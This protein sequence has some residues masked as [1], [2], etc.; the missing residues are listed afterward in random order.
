MEQ[1][2]T[3][4]GN[5]SIGKHQKSI[6]NKEQRYEEPLRK[7]RSPNSRKYLNVTI[8][9]LN[10]KTH[11]DQEC[12]SIRNSSRK[13]FLLSTFNVRTLRSEDR[14]LELEYGL[15]QTNYG[16]MGMSE[17]R[18][19]GEG[20]MVKQNGDLFSYIGANTSHKGVGFIINAALKDYVTMIEGI[21]ERITVL[22][23]KVDAIKISIIQVYAP[24]SLSSEEELDSFYDTLDITLNSHRSQRN[25]VMGD[26]NAKIGNK[27]HEDELAVGQHSSGERNESG[28]RLIQFAESQNLK[29]INSFFHKPIQDK[30]TWHSPDGHTKNEIDFILTDH[31]DSVK[32]FQIFP[33]PSFE[34]DHRVVEI[35]IKTNKDRRKFRRN[36][37]PLNNNI[38]VDA[39]RFHLEDNISNIH[40]LT[41]SGIQEQYNVVE[42]AITKAAKQAS[43]SQFNQKRKQR[44]C[45]NTI[46]LLEERE[47]LKSSRFHSEET[48]RQYAEINKRVKREIRKDI[49]KHKTELIQEIMLSSKSTRAIIQGLKSDKHWMLR[50]NNKHGKSTSIRKE[51]NEEAT[52]FFKHLYTSR[53][54]DDYS[55]D[56]TESV[57]EDLNS[58]VPPII[59]S[60]IRSIIEKLKTSKCPGNDGILN[61]HLKTGLLQL[62]PMLTTLFN[63]ILE[64]EEIPDQWLTNTITLIHKKGTRTDINN[65]RPISIMSNVYKI[66]SMIINRRISGRLDEEQP[67]EQAGFRQ[68]FSTTDHLQTIN[69]I[70]EKVQEFNLQLYV[71]FI[72]FT[73][74]FDTVE[75]RK[76][77]NALKNQGINKKYIRM[78]ELIYSKSIAKVKTEYEGETFHLNRGVR[79]GDPISPKLFNCLLEDVFRH[80][81]WSEDA[82]IKIHGKCLTNLRFADDIVLFATSASK[83]ENMVRELSLQSVKAGLHINFQKTKIM[84]NRIEIPV[85]I[86]GVEIQYVQEYIYLGQLISFHNG[87]DKEINRRMSLAWNKFW[88]LAFILL[89]RKTSI[90]IKKT[91]MD[92]CILPVLLYGAQTWSLTIAQKIKIERCQRKMER[93]ILQIKLRDRIRNIDIRNKSGITDA[94]TQATKLKWKW[95]GHVMRQE[96]HKWAH[97]ATTWDPMTGWRKPGR[98]KRRWRDVFTAE[99]GST[100]SQEARDRRKWRELQTHS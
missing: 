75:H 56:I 23:L 9:T 66:F 13:S 14:V 8:A 88:S 77:L 48:R 85:S 27:Q 34:S 49:R 55:F 32:D 61:E 36:N 47:E 60:E 11:K 79:Q 17:V 91:V 3:F 30:W 64:K 28:E 18:K 90:R 21:T 63:S 65:Y 74:A 83:L 26:F 29:I 10:R 62:T 12:K 94:T 2:F 82:G 100:W 70:L 52:S 97:I 35:K 1:F 89:D 43:R 6:N 42:E 51:I 78:L 68:G 39:Y 20:I 5:T 41:E 31:L 38:D 76:I 81:N 86:D 37:A 50:I 57:E 24:T 95:C 25:Y 33:L 96:Q 15:N 44:L 58:D 67:P 99:I 84:T 16:I 71:A 72:D 4:N 7:K 92:S 93:K 73:K 80:L 69:Q 87:S 22:K 98:P 53:I 54:D 59:N 19:V 40:C 45:G 46:Q